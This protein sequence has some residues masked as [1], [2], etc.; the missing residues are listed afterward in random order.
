MAARVDQ[1][2]GNSMYT[3]TRARMRLRTQRGSDRRDWMCRHQSS[4]S[5]LFIA[6]NSSFSLGGATVMR[7]KSLNLFI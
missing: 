5:I 6:N 1:Y 7:A 3:H 4:D 2:I